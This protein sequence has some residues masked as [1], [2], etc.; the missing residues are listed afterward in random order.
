MSI[1]KTASASFMYPS[2]GDPKPRPN[3]VVLLIR[4]DN[5][6]ERGT[7]DDSCKAWAALHAEERKKPKQTSLNLKA[8]T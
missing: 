5:T 1:L 7:W 6:H 3:Q 8:P 2:L 4:T